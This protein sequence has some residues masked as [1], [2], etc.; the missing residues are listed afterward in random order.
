MRTIEQLIGEL[1]PDVTDEAVLAAIANVRREAFVSDYLADRAYDNRALPIGHGQTISQ[2]LV[3]ALMATAA[4]IPPDGRVLEIGTGSGYAAA[5]LSE[6]AAEVGTEEF[7][8][9]K[10]RYKQPGAG[11]D[12]PATEVF[13]ALSPTEIKG[14][15][16]E[17][18]P[19]AQWA[20]GVASFA[21][22]LRESP[23]VDVDD[24]GS[25]REVLAP[26]AS[27]VERAELLTLF[28]QTVDLLQGS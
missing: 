2:P 14:T 20:I 10:V 22:V 25:I 15:V 19:D 9:V 6:L 26:L 17:A 23:Y 12:D 16:S 4:Q 1:R 7:V 13:E 28:D 24:L 21:E 3:V 27:G 11:T 18:D 8:R 5:V